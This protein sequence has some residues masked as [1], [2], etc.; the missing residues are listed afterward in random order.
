MGYHRADGRVG[1]RNYWLVLP[2][3]RGETQQLALLKEALM[4]TLGYQSANPYLHQFRAL[5]EQYRAGSYFEAPPPPYTGRASLPLFANIDGVRFLPNLYEQDYS[6]D[7]LASFWP[8]LAGYCTH[9][10][11]GGITVLSM[12]GSDSSPA[13]DTI[14]QH[15]VRGDP[16]FCKPFVIADRFAYANEFDWLSAAT[17]NTFH[18][19]AALNKQTRRPAPL[20]RLTVGVRWGEAS[21]L[22]ANPAVGYCVQAALELGAT[23]LMVT[24]DSR[25]DTVEKAAHPCP[26]A[27]T[28]SAPGLQQCSFPGNTVEVTTA[29]IAAGCTLHLSTNESGRPTGNPVAP[30][31]ELAV[32]QALADRMADWIDIDCTDCGGT[33]KDTTIAWMGETIL[34]YSLKLASGEQLTQSETRGQYDFKVYQP[35]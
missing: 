5:R 23:V 12:D 22:S 14:R 20:S 6:P 26:T 2:L 8:L 33:D 31:V 10:N 19:M 35:F 25:P 13:V 3:F 24:P 15:I 1:T 30:V 18:A 27:R 16:A 17:S 4:T 9:P 32:R 29:L 34:Q 11:V 7:T 28:V 21:G